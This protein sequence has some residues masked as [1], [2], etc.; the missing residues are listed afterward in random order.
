MSAADPTLS[1]LR[2]AQQL[3]ASAAEGLYAI[4]TEGACIA[5]NPAGVRILGY[6]D[7]EELLG[8]NMHQMIH[9]TRPD[10]S[11]YPEELCRIAVAHRLGV[12]VNRDDELFFRR[13][14]SS[15]PAEYRSSPIVVDGETRGTVLTFVDITDRRRADAEAARDRSLQRIAG[16]TARVG[17]WAIDLATGGLTWSEE[18]YRIHDLQPGEELDL[19]ALMRNY[20][21][22]DR[23]RV[24]A[25]VD[26]C[27]THGEAFDLE[28]EYE[29]PAGRR[30]TLRAIGEP[31]RDRDGRVVEIV[32]AI[33]DITQLKE[34]ARRSG[35][36][37]ERLETTLENI[38]DG[39]FTL[40]RDWRVTF[41]NRRA[42]QLLRRP[43]EG[44]L[45][46]VVWD[47]FP[48]AAGTDADRAVRRA[49]DE[50]ATIVLDD[51]H[52]PP[53]SAWFQSTIYPSEHGLAVYFRDVT[54]QHQAR[55]RLA[56]RELQVAEQAALLDAARD[57]IHV[58]DLDHRITFWN[59]SAE[60][61][62]GHDRDTVLGTSARDLLHDDPAA[63]DAAM[64]DL[65]R[66]GGW[67]GELRMTTSSGGHV[68][69]EARWTLV[70]DADGQPRSVLAIESDVTERRLLDQ[71]L[72]QAQR[73]DSL[74]TL[75]G[76]IA[77][78][79]NNVL[80]PILLAVQSLQMQEVDATTEAMLDIIEEST[81]R[82]TQ[83]LRQILSFARGVDGRRAEL[84][85]ETV[86]ADV[87]R[88]TQQTFPDEISIDHE[89]RD[90]LPPI[91]GDPTQLHQVLM[92]LCVN[93]RDAM[94]D[95]GR[96]LLAA[97][98]LEIVES[99]A[100]IY[101]VPAGWYVAIRVEDEGSGM[102]P[103]TITRLF[104][105]FFTTK[106]AG[107]G[108]GL[109][110][111]TAHGIVTSH[112]GFFRVYSEPGRGS[113]FKVFLPALTSG[114]GPQDGR[115]DV[116]APPRGAGQLVLVVDDDDASRAAIRAILEQANYRVLDTGDGRQALELVATHTDE[117]EVLI[118]DMSMPR[119][120][121]P[122]LVSS[123]LETSPDLRVI[124]ISGLS[125]SRELARAAHVGVE[126]FLPKPF[127]AP[128]LLATIDRAIRG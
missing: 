16:A 60:H 68:T 82:G 81:V 39:F 46:K 20:V 2:L 128:I 1:E 47:E 104:E 93:A 42:E 100:R 25:A 54:E 65:L 84:D 67:N 124:A 114:Q 23:A 59:V 15:F 62:F 97:E 17:G 71:Q 24:A 51:F 8:R 109:G 61:L 83:M 38:T 44:L 113:A 76:G 80:A 110:L 87:A 40:D 85:I 88:L 106:E 41:M 119:M 55:T 13:D 6:D 5:V 74:G 86:L 21:G 53:L 33:Q 103:E 12:E 19:R 31:R 64:A 105:P 63:F 49:M 57:A 72:L 70:R 10:G 73:L 79:L 45:G 43:R 118:S 22:A 108:T 98:A 66:T 11:P 32:G 112:G 14:G 92:N 56:E 34:A 90:D 35:E 4:D 7:E 37:E 89:P 115:S 126:Q 50:H 77:H 69:V 3:L 102:E 96:I 91:L 29:T 52:Y 58:R 121:G 125:A 95:G 99:S 107:K 78:D 123:A 116:S 101:D 127:P 48:D 120:D 27:T 9:H 94:P 122:T 26:R 30:S 36:L 111:P 18:T 75:A 28:A 117:L